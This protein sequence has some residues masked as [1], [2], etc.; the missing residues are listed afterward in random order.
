MKILNRQEL[1]IA[2]T[3]RTKINQIMRAK[4]KKENITIISSN[5]IGG[6]LYHDL[7][8]QF[9]SPTINM[10]FTCEDF[11][12]FVE[13]IDYYLGIKPTVVSEQE[14]P[15]LQ[16]YDIKLYCKHYISAESAIEK[17]ELRKKRINK[18]AIYVVATDRDCNDKKSLYKI[19]ALKYPKVIF[20]SNKDMNLKSSIYVPGYY[21]QVGHLD[22]FIDE[23]GYRIYE[24][25]FNFVD[26]FNSI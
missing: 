22:R 2:Y 14:F 4:L 21:E 7:G 12:K 13:N 24:E 26:W 19:N 20:V 3:N 9:Q 11:V 1:E 10:F 15:I 25:Y 8:L 18:K 17:W 16:L 5:C 6:I 23:N